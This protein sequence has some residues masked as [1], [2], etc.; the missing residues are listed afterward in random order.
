MPV[1]KRQETIGNDYLPLPN[2]VF[3][4]ACV[5]IWGTKTRRRN[6]TIHASLDFWLDVC[7]IFGEDDV[8]THGQA[9]FCSFFE[10][11]QNCCLLEKLL[12]PLSTSLLNTFFVHYSRRKKWI[13]VSKVSFRLTTHYFGMIL[14]IQ[15]HLCVE[16]VSILWA[17]PQMFA[18]FFQSFFSSSIP[19]WLHWNWF[20]D[21]F[22]TLMKK[23]GFKSVMVCTC[24]L[25]K[26][27]SW[28]LIIALRLTQ[29]HL[30]MVIWVTFLHTR[31]A[32]TEIQTWFSML[33][34]FDRL[35]SKM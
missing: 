14:C 27:P 5:E 19:F 9:H 7:N 26:Y 35:D 28:M 20:H 31:F 10:F 21:F 11:T 22:N 29:P 16:Q 15:G 12:W 24:V 17:F 23:F 2:R 4:H 34:C 18:Q 13:W 8:A 6:S 1:G 3:V 30:F 33:C 25:G 32:R